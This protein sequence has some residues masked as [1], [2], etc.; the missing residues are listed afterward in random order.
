MNVVLNGL[1]GCGFDPLG[2]TKP[3]KIVPTVILLGT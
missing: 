2:I 3:I 1:V